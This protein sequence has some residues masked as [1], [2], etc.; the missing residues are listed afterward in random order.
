MRKVFVLGGGG[1]LGSSFIRSVNQQE[2]EIYPCDINEVNHKNFI[3]M[4]VSKPETMK[5]LMNADIILNLAAVHRDDIKPISKY[6]DVNVK[7]AKNICDAA[8]QYNVNKII[9]ISSVAIYGFAPK[10]TNEE[11]EAN[12]FNDYGRTKYLAEQIFKKWQLENSNERSLVIIR[13]TVIFGEGNRGNVFNLINAIASKKFVMFGDGSNKKSMAYVENV[14]SFISNRLNSKPG[15][16]IYNYVDKP[17][18]TTKELV[19]FSRETLFRNKTLDIRLPKFLGYLVGYLF[20]FLSILLRRKLSIS[21]IRVKKFFGESS[22]DAS[23]KDKIFKPSFSLKEGLKRTITYEFLE[24]NSD[25]RTFDT[26]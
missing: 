15:I 20:D 9:F 3:F 26:E 7:G 18:L 22:F 6:D 24:D 13:P 14:S 16:H 2:N 17:D 23:K 19:T 11:G 4:D 25:K 21:S 12:Y 8:T 5:S 1:F 10:N